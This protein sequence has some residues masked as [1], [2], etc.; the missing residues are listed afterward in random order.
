M[1]KKISKIEEN[2]I[3]FKLLSNKQSVDEVL[4]QGAVK[5]TIQTLYDK[6][7]LIVM[8]MQMKY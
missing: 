4:I 3:E 7:F 5:T 8:T 2:Y 6:V 1:R